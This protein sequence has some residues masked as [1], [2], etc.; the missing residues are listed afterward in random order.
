MTGRHATTALAWRLAAS[1]PARPGLLFGLDS[2][3]YLSNHC[4]PA[5]LAPDGV[6]VVHVARYLAPG[7]QPDRHTGHAELMAH[8]F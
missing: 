5:R 1:V 4:P 7:E 2:P 3:L 6:S 8:A